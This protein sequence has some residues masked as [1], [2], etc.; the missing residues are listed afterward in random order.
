MYTNM[1]KLFTEIYTSDMETQYKIIDRT[2]QDW[3]GDLEQVDD[4]LIIDIKFKKS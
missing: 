2:M 1:K 3:E 4:M